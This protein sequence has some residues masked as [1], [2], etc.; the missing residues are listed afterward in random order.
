MKKPIDALELGGTLFVPGVHKYLTAIVNGEKFPSLRSMVIDL[1]DGIHT[2]QRRDGLNKVHRL[3]SH[4]KAADLF[5]FIRPDSPDTLEQLLAM[6]GIDQIDG[7]VLPKVGLDNARNY[8][9]LLEGTGFCFMPSIEGR[10]LFDP[11]ALIEL[12]NVLLPYQHYIPVIRFGAEDMFRQLGLRRECDVSLYDMAAASMVIGS[13]LGTFKPYGFDIAAPVYRCYKDH[14]GFKRDVMRDLQEGLVS[15]T[16]IHPDQITLLEE[17]YRVDEESYDAALKLVETK[18][19][20]FSQEG[21]MAESTTQ[22]PWAERILKRA[23]LYGR[24]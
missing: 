14:E 13:L 17:C 2:D 23:A 5:R 20:V 9:D 10:E 4:L 15:K 12:R 7:F 6:E 22:S 18:E 19:A 11:N 21:A 8:L 24:V 16:I 1:E 3:L